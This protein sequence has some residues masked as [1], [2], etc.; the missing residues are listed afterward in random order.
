MPLLPGVQFSFC[1][2]FASMRPCYSQSIELFNHFHKMPTVLPKRLYT[3]ESGEADAKSLKEAMKGLVA[4]EKIVIS[5]LANRSCEQRLEIAAIFFSIYSKNLVDE[6]KSSFISNDFVNTTVALLAPLE[7]FYVRELKYA[8]TASFGNHKE[9]LCEI[10][11][12]LDM[13]SLL[14]V[15]TCYLESFETKLEADIIEKKFPD[16]FEQFLLKICG[17]QRGENATLEEIQ[18]E[19]DVDAIYEACNH[20]DAASLDGSINFITNIL[21]RRSLNHLRHIFDLFY[22]L[23]GDMRKV[24]KDSFPSPIKEAFYAMITFASDSDGF[25]AERLYNS[26]SG[27]GTRDRDLIRL[28]V[29][30]A[31]I[32]LG[33]IKVAFLH[34]YGKTLES[35]IEGD[36][37][38]DYKRI[39]LALIT[40]SILKTT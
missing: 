3:A 34:M 20:T 5:I 13:N 30:R 16:A 2:S 4:D 23:H 40:P 18:I 24:I 26:M 19:E 11:C 32:D 22:L 6:L 12:S 25:F 31:E 8:L 33:D 15:K 14:L 28:V 17:C 29:S 39:L 9:T 10:L 21:T 27:F 7:K 35:F 36:C 1:F 37:S 38:G